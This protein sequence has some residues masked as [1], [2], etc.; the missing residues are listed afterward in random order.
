[1]CNAAKAFARL[2]TK[3]VAGRH[4]LAVQAFKDVNKPSKANAPKGVD[5]AG[6]LVWFGLS[7]GS[8]LGWRSV[9]AATSFAGART[10]QQAY[11]AV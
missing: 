1:L 7:L 6:L 8:G 10:V 2:D 3:A 11:F 9:P 5:S 4:L